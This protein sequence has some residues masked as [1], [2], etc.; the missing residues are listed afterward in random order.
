MHLAPLLTLLLVVATPSQEDEQR[1]VEGVVAEL[2]FRADDADPSLIDELARQGSPAA[3]DGLLTAYDAMQSIY[4]RRAVIRALV[5]FDET[6]RLGRRAVQKLVD[7]ATQASV[8]EVRRLAVEAI[9]SCRKHGRAFLAAIVDSHAT[10]EVRELAMRH[11]AGDPRSADLDWYRGHYQRKRAEAGDTGPP[12]LPAIRE[13]AFEALAARLGLEE[14]LEAMR[15]PLREIRLGALTE[16]EARQAGEV[17]K[18]ATR[19]YGNSRARPADRLD[20][21]K[22]LARLHGADMAERFAK[23]GRRRDFPEELVRGLAD[24]LA[25]FEDPDVEKLLVRRVGKGKDRELLFSLWSTAH[26]EDE[27]VD[28]AL[29]KALRSKDPRVLR[30]AARILGARHTEGAVEELARVIEKSDDPAV[31]ATAFEVTG[32][33]RG[34]DPD[35]WA[36]LERTA[37]HATPEVRNSAITALGRSKRVEFVPVLTASLENEDWSTRLAAARALEAV[38]TAECVAALCHRIP[39]EIGRLAKEMGEI[40]F[41]LSG[42]P[43]AE[44]GRL[45]AAWWEREGADFRPI[46]PAA[47]RK[48]EREEEE[49]RLR[50][51]TRTTFFGI[52]IHSHS[53]LF[54]IDVSG[55]MDELMLGRDPGEKGEPRIV[56]AKR[57]LEKCIE[58]LKRASFFNV[59]AYSDRVLP[60]AEELTALESE[61]RELAKEYVRGLRT[62]GGTNLFGALERA[63]EDPA[64]DTI[65][66]ISDGEASMGEIIDPGAI[67][68]R[69]ASM[70]ENR[71][72]RIHAIAIGYDLA[73]LAALAQDSGGIYL[74]LY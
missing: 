43:Y 30:E 66:L 33:L 35:W 53:V 51:T 41:R 16:L 60:W 26:I 71:G 17:E 57:E 42:R 63:F 18:L 46:E 64:V 12:P 22:I 4:M 72:V 47:L 7:I 25:G 13:L 15:D 37:G 69:I 44:N 20:A 73:V 56:R 38:G 8:R 24:I 29:L 31:L 2:V 11:H 65:Y 54:V 48:R 36:Q 74:E 67:R 5:R 10:P 21:A 50:K 32:E 52:E 19:L 39:Q 28:K 61:T 34:D 49:R 58:G 68:E 45:W 27:K 1:D 59:L 23:D 9:A 6:P 70:N 40:L 62:G 3:L 14:L 55:S